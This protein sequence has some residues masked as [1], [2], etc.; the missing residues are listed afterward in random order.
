MARSPEHLFTTADRVVILYSTFGRPGQLAPVI[1]RLADEGAN[2]VEV[3]HSRLFD[4]AS[5]RQTF[6]EVQIE[7]RDRHHTDQVI[8]ALRAD[9][10][11]VRE[12]TG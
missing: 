11:E 7:T 12:M 6:I 10:L 5:V 2:I 3:S 4:P 1:D 9:G 8:A